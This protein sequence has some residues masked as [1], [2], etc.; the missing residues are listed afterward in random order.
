LKEVFKKVL[1]KT[2]SHDIISTS[3]GKRREKM[4]FYRIYGYV[5]VEVEANSEREALEIFQEECL[6]EVMSMLD[7]EEYEEEE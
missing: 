6:D 7:I 1:T 3:K 4:K 5:E 2:L